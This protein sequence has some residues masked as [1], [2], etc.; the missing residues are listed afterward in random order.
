M[1]DT[2]DVAVRLVVE[3]RIVCDIDRCHHTHLMPFPLRPTTCG[4]LVALSFI[5]R[6]PAMKPMTVGANFTEIVQLLRGTKGKMHMNGANKT[7]RSC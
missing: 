7:F 3:A 2:R 4:V 6:D 1:D 5:V